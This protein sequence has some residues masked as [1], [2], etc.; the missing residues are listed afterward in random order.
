MDY[1]LEDTSINEKE[2]AKIK[3]KLKVSF[4]LR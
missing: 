2:E 3:T 4:R 1:W